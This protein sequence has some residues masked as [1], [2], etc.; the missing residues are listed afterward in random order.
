[1]AASDTNRAASQGLTL[2][3]ENWVYGGAGLAREGGQV[4]LLPYVLAG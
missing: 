2:D 4:V 3:V 1:M